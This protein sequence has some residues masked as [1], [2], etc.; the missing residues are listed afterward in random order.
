MF[1]I[2]TS[3]SITSILLPTDYQTP[4]LLLLFFSTIVFKERTRNIKSFQKS[5]VYM[6]Q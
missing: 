5:K 3:V 6:E 1:V 4:N 2:N